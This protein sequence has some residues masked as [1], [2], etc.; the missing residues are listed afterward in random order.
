[1]ISP[2][3]KNQGMPID[4]P[5]TTFQYTL[6]FFKRTEFKDR[7][8]MI[9]SFKINIMLG[10]PAFGEGVILVNCLIITSFPNKKKLVW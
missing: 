6:A 1:M 2:S 7:K 5:W 8:T 4:E 10:S 9:Q 3:S